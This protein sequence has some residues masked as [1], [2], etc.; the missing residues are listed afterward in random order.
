[1]SSTSPRCTSP[2]RPLGDRLSEVLG[3]DGRVVAHQSSDGVRLLHAYV[4][5]TS[6]AA[7]RVAATAAEW[8]QGD[9]QTV[10]T[11][12]PGWALVNHLAG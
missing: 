10:V 8:D 2:G 7:D 5:G 11:P 9:A 6:E 1:M 4:D 12:D 3:A